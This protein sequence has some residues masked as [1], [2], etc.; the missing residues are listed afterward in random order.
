MTRPRFEKVGGRQVRTLRSLKPGRMFIWFNKTFGASGWYEVLSEPHQ[1]KNG[2]WRM[3]VSS[4][5][6]HGEIRFTKEVD[7]A[8]YNVV[9]SK[10]NGWD[11]FNCLL[12]TEAKTSKF[13]ER[14]KTEAFQP[15]IP[16][17]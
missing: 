14:T 1:E 11:S 12:R 2:S 6:E 4:I 10:W 9:P 13:L 7:L 17:S 3:K 5:D 8:D 15:I 16:S